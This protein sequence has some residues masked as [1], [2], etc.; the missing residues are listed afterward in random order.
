VSYRNQDAWR[1]IQAFLP[2]DYQLA[3]DLMPAEEWWSWDGHIIHLDCFR[4]A[5]APAKVVLFHGLGTN[6]RQMSTLLGGQL[7]RNGLEAIAIDMPGYGVTRNRKG[8]TVIYDDW[9]RA[10]CALVEAEFARDS[11]PIYLYGLSAGGMLAYHVAARGRNVRGVIGM[12][13]LDQR[14]PRV[15]AETAL[16]PTLA[17]LG[18]P[19]IMGAARTP[20]ASLRLPMTLISK[21]HTLVNDKAALRACL[22]DKTSAGAWA[23]FAFLNSY[24]SYSPEMEPEDFDVCPILLTQPAEDRWTPL[25]LSELF[26]RRVAK[27]RKNIV[28]LDRAG[29]YPLE[30]P[31]LDQLREA[32]LNFVSPMA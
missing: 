26:L 2:A 9:V 29:H 10:G 16:H 14:E 1:K 25:H 7:A 11:R 22:R 24:L 17:G 13:F 3:G 23:T 27:A 15:R 20:L 28:M 30:Q 12:A 8:V 31:G 18:V 32:V 5:E 6:G 21:M 19:L 4:T